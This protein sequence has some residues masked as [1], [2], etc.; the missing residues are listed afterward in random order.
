MA[1]ATGGDEGSPSVRSLTGGD[2]SRPGVHDIDRS[3]ILVIDDEPANLSLLDELLRI[4]GFTDVRTTTEPAEAVAA[5]AMEQV[6]LVVADLR[7]PGVEGLD[8]LREIQGRTARSDYLPVLV[9]TAHANAAMKREALATGAHDFLVKPFDAD[10]L[11]LRIRNLLATRAL[12]VEV[13]QHR[14]RL[15]EALLRYEAEAT[16]RAEEWATK[17]RR[18]EQALSPSAF[19]LVFQPVFDVGASRMIGLE[20]LT[21]FD[22]EPTRPPNEWFAEAEEVDLSSA[23]QLGVIRAGVAALDRVPAPT[24]LALNLSADVLV[25]P[26]LDEI[27][28]GVDLSRIVLELTEHAP[29]ADYELVHDALRAWREEGL[30]FA[31]DDAGA[32]YASFQHILRLRPDIIKLDLALTRGIDR[33][34]IRRSLAAALVTFGHEMDAVLVAEGVETAEELHALAAL[35]FDAAQGYHLG[36]PAPLDDVLAGERPSGA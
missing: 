18:V 5:V 27:L 25:A 2:S 17:R 35:G 20:G 7:M 23:L 29:V 1:P 3:R 34:P 12:H 36:R 26:E 13:D 31:I 22:L 4:D 32:G 11:L 24:F 19:H 10:E 15:E 9:L 16:R 28:R 6:D 33:D 8:L 14:R 21:R 30:R